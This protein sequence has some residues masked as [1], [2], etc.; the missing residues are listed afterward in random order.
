[1]K[2]ER[3]RPA[4][5]YLDNSATTPIHETV[6]QTY[7]TASQEFFANPSSL[8]D[9]GEK[10]RQLLSQ[11]RQ[12]LAS[13]LG[14]RPEE[15]FFT[16]GGSESINWAIKG[17]AIEKRAF[18][19]H[20]IT[21]SI[22]HSAVFNSF[23]ELETLGF[24]CTYLSVNDEGQVDLEELKASIRPDT[25]L[26]SIIAVNNEVGC[27]QPL[28]AI[29]QILE[30]HPNIH[31]HVDGVQAIGKIPI[32]LSSTSRIDLASFSGHKFHGPKGSG[33]LYKKS[34]R[35]LKALIHGGG[36][37]NAMRSGTENTPTIAAMVKAARLLFDQPNLSSQQHLNQILRD[38][39][40]PLDRIHIF[41]P[42]QAAPHILCFG[43]EG[44]RGEVV[45]HA[46][47]EDGIYLS[48]TSACSSRQRSEGST[49]QAMGVP[50]DLAQTAVR[51]SLSPHTTDQEIQGFL[52][53]FER[54]Y[55]RFSKLFEKE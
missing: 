33:F 26:V 51:L 5:I 42:D 20:L 25:T 31:F 53:A 23:K 11:S 14:C 15:L 50:K 48:T 4:V 9:L 22:E 13:T 45:V 28:D 2:D 18:G 16:S 21:T 29:G 17:T 46:L 32:D 38:R 24:E 52:Q 19:K 54:H 55:Q 43:T 34:N 27:I 37:E 6:L 49:L 44:I 7:I 10:S 3:G 30:D 8:H 12:Q 41:S 47:E 40:E 39:L 36:Q 35:K 1:M